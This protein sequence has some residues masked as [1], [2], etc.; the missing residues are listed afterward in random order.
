MTVVDDLT[1]A[2]C[3]GCGA[4]DRL[5]LKRNRQGFV[6]HAWLP[7][8]WR[9]IHDQTLCPDC[10]GENLTMAVLPASAE[11]ELIA[12]QITQTIYSAPFAEASRRQQEL[13]LTCARK[14]MSALTPPR[15]EAEAS[16]VA[17]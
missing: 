13:T 3:T 6:T 12:D 2:R 7:E 14:I 9:Q 17:A 8:G 1:P 15:S 5:V 4:S 11:L 10:L 16:E